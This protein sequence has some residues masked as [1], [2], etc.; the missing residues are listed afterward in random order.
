MEL[1]LEHDAF[2]TRVLKVRAAN[3]W[4]GPRLIVNGAEAEGK[5]NKYTVRDDEGKERVITLKASFLDPIPKVQ[6]DDETPV[7]LARPLRW[8]EYAWMAAPILLVFMCGALGGALGGF[9]GAFAFWTSTRIFRSDRG[10][11]AKYGMSGLVSFGAFV[12]FVII[13]ATLHTVLQV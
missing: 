8:Y 4:K 12:T 11:V 6:F 7:A 9:L 13:A 10:T 3:L 1:K 5:R 2:R